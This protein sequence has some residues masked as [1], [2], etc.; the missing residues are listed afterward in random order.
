[1]SSAN[2]ETGD[3]LRLDKWLWAAR[4]YK[5]RQLAQDAIE[6]GRVQLNGERVK[7]SRVVRVGDRL[8]LRINQLEY[9]VEVLVL[10]SQRRS[11]PEAQQL[12]REDAA[13][14][15]AR[16]QRSLLL[17]AER[18]SFP[19]G[20]GRPSKKARREISKFKDSF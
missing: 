13:S 10:A 3:K 16:E 1:M 18:S 19:H 9:H 20:E 14:I 12:Y 2:A 17:K 15:A 8:L 4:F 7:P 5:T 11:A 6:L